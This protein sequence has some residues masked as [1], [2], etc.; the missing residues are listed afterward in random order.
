MVIYFLPDVPLTPNV[1]LI[2]SQKA[3][4][5]PFN[6]MIPCSLCYRVPSSRHSRESGN[7]GKHI[8]IPGQA[9]ND[10]K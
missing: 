10:R 3:N 5:Y 9:R 7:P 1:N 8:W 4:F 2:R 6:L